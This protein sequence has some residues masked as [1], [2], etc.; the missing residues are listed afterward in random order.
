M[1]SGI[2]EVPEP[3]EDAAAFAGRAA[4]EKAMEVAAKQPGRWVLGADTVVVIDG[5]ILGKPSG[6]AEA[7]SMLRCLSGRVH[8]VLTGVALIA[9]DGRRIADLVVRSSVE[10]RELSHEEINAYAESGEPLDKAGAYA[11]QGGA[12]RF[13]LGVTGS[14][15]NVIG[16]PIEEVQRLL[17]DCGLLDTSDGCTSFDPPHVA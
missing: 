15:S 14:Y 1:A 5:R 12:G 10:F 9:P 13:V 17:L 16:L 3:G 8:H 7:R 11:I 2:P 6:A 4:F